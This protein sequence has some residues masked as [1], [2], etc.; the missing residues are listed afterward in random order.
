MKKLMKKTK[1]EKLKEAIKPVKEL[2][3]KNNYKNHKKHY[4]MM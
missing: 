3:D 1:I 2:F 4:I